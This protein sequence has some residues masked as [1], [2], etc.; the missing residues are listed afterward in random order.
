M[1]VNRERLVSLLMGW[2]ASAV[3]FGIVALL[4]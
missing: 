4:I 2:A 3:I 1:N